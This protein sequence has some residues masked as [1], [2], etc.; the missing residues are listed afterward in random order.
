MYH[1]WRVRLAPRDVCKHNGNPDEQPCH[2]HTRGRYPPRSPQGPVSAVRHRNVGAIQLLRHACAAGIVDGGRG[3]N[4]QPGLWLDIGRSVAPVWAV[5]GFCVLHA[6]DRGL[7]RRQLPRPASLGD[8]WRRGHGARSIHP[9]RVDP[10][11]PA[12]VL[13]RAAPAG[14]RQRVFQ[15]QYFDHGRRPLPEGRRPSR[16]RVHDFLHGHQSR[17][18]SCSAGVLHA[19]R[20]PGTGLAL[21][22]FRG[23]LRHDPVGDH[24]ACPGA[25]L[26]AGD[27][28]DTIRTTLAAAGWRRKEAADR[29]RAR[30]ATRDLHAVCFHRAV[31]GG[32]RAGRGTDESLRSRQD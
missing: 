14:D 15:G 7:A 12:T 8:H 18:I 5:H 2:G 32:V 13:L 23:R 28:D 26:S 4:R 19:R 31:L 3:R 25:A 11:Q 30:P 29:D 9:R 10:G 20:K 27:R 16:W 22:I 21:R 6:T 17:S 24:P 1:S